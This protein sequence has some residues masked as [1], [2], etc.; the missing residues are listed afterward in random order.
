MHLNALFEGEN[1][2]KISGKGH[3][4]SQTQ[5]PLGMPLLCSIKTSK[6]PEQ[7]F[8]PG[9]HWGLCPRAQTPFVAL[10]NKILLPRP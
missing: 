10:P 5:T 4:P 8:T 1:A 2:K 3:S 6:K 9:A 7:G